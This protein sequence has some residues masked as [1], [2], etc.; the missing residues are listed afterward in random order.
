MIS[1]SEAKKIILSS[2]GLVKGTLFGH[3]LEGTRQAIDHL[4]YVQIDT[5]SVVER[6]HHHVLWSRVQNYKTDF[7]NQLMAEKS[8]F[9]Y[10]SHA[11]AYLPM[12]DFRFSLPRKQLFASGKRKWFPPTHENMKLK[13]YVY[14]R[15]KSEGP[16]GA[17][18]F[19]NT[20]R[21]SSGWW[22]WKPAKQALEQLFLEG[23]L[24]ISG[25][26]GFQKNY[27][28]TERVLP[29]EVNQKMPTES[30]MAQHLILKS[31]T[32]H[33]LIRS[34]E[35]AYQRSLIRKAVDREC[36]ILVHDRI[37]TELKVEGIDLPYYGLSDQWQKA[38]EGSLSKKIQILSPFDNHVIQRK[39]L[40][41]LFGF[42][43]TIE[44]Y[45]PEPKRQY[46]YF[47]LP[48]LRGDQFIGRIDA[49]ADRKTKVLTVRS[50]HL[51]KGCGRK[52]D[53][54]KEAQGSLKDFS[55]FN[56]CSRT[57]FDSN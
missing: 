9:E 20:R 6:A 55:A 32:A 26:K 43:Y 21:K 36:K 2:Q 25:R 8:I 24:M 19:E 35:I 23:E 30:E 22:D 11:A 1:L 3:G 46:G 50:L 29:K 7:L 17:R 42:D 40:R 37:L 4:G 34:D 53:L 48:L 15:I 13:K 33:G 10:W 44:C 16:L 49:K 47:S 57:Q 38:L 28:L 12:T 39:R 27:D 31:V 45:V 54:W 41:E 56:G 51:E 14:A 52:P 5:I 18:E